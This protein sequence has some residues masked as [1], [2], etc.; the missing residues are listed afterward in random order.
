MCYNCTKFTGIDSVTIQNMKMCVELPEVGPR[1]T[2]ALALRKLQNMVIQNSLLHPGMLQNIIR[3]TILD[4]S[5]TGFLSYYVIFPFKGD[6]REFRECI[7]NNSPLC[8]AIV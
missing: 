5:I 4:F 1:P 8:V 6:L 3:Q 7:S 2:K